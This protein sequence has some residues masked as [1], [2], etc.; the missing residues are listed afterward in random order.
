MLLG[1]KLKG[2][3]I[4]LWG[5]Y[6]SILDELDMW[7]GIPKETLA[8]FGY[9]DLDKNYILPIPLKGTLEQPKF[10]WEHAS[11]AIGKLAL[12]QVRNMW[13]EEQG[14]LKGMIKSA[15]A[16]AAQ[17]KLESDDGKGPEIPELGHVK[18]PWNE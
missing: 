1:S 13:P 12:S 10:D 9:T 7:V 4:V 16:T 11:N 8:R 14:T 18:F 17:N 2:I 6:N 5:T 15:L 3:H